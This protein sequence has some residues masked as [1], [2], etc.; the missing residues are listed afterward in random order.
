MLR[1]FKNLFREKK[2]LVFRPDYKY[3]G[4]GVAIKEFVAFKESIEKA[5]NKEPVMIN[6]I[7]T[8]NGEQIIYILEDKK[9]E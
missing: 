6:N 1:W 7:S 8:W 9:D 3:G 2:H 5:S 4:S